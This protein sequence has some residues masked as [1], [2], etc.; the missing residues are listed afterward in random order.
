MSRLRHRRHSLDTRDAGG[1]ST[2][3]IVG[4][5]VGVAVGFVVIFGLL[6]WVC[7]PKMKNVVV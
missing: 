2:G 3:G 5:C 4:A 6:V 7:K 1:V